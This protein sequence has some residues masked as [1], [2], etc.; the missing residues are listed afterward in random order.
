MLECNLRVPLPSQMIPN[1]FPK[2]TSFDH[3][4]EVNSQIGQ[5]TTHAFTNYH[6][7]K[8]MSPSALFP[9][10]HV[11]VQT[12]LLISSGW[13]SEEENGHCEDRVP[14]K[15]KWLKPLPRETE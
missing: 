7:P 9:Q 15:T 8:N 11:C 5:D 10:S 13:H 12:T 2:I 4:L 6:C 3:Q 14:L 1:A